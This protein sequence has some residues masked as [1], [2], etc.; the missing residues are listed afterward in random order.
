M[1]IAEGH[2]RAAKRLLGDARTMA[3][4]LRTSTWTPCGPC[5]PITW[6]LIGA[7]RVEMHQDTALRMGRPHHSGGVE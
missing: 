3:D 5:P 4:A 2:D 6:T 1:T 7:I